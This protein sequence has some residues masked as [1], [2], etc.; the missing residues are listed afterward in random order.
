[1]LIQLCRSNHANYHDSFEGS[2]TSTTRI[3]KLLSRLL[4]AALAL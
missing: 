4:Y 1:M 2:T 3:Y